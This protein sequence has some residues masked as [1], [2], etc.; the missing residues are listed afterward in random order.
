MQ[1]HNLKTHV[2]YFEATWEGVKNFEIRLNDRDY[3][4]GDNLVLLE[5][6]H[7]NGKVTGRQITS[8]VQYVLHGDDILLPKHYVCMNT[9][10]VEKFPTSVRNSD[11]LITYL[12]G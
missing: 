5:W 6:D 12:D 7:V 3:H 11:R 8:V 2:E 1:T 4:V 10:I 9:V